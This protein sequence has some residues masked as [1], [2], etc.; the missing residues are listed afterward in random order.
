MGSAPGQ[1]GGPRTVRRR[2]WCVDANRDV[3]VEFI[4]SGLPGF[5]RLRG[6]LRCP[7]NAGCRQ[8]CLDA[9]FRRRW[10]PALPVDGGPPG[11]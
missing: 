4:A 2:F 11:D 10:P 5:R 3:E 8:G 7:V 1:N 9:A 6:V